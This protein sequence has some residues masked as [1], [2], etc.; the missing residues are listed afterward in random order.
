MEEAVLGGRKL[1]LIGQA[2]QGV[3]SSISFIY[4]LDILLFFNTI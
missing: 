1:F 2:I 3:C 4:G